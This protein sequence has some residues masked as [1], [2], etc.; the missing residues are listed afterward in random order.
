MTALTVDHAGALNTVALDLPDVFDPLLRPDRRAAR[1][2]DPLV[3]TF[4]GVQS[5]KHLIESMGIPHTEIAGLQVNGTWQSLDYHPQDGERLYV[6]PVGGG[7]QGAAPY[8]GD[9][10]RFVLDNHLGKLATYLRLLGFDCFYDQQLEDE[11]LARLSAEQ[12]R[13]LLSRDRG[14]LMRRQVTYGCWVASKTP[15]DQ[16]RLVLARYRLY[17]QVNPFSRCLRCNHPLEPVSKAEIQHRLLPLTK[18]YYEEFYLCR[19]CGQI[20]WPGSHY[21]HLEQVIAELLERRQ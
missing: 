12:T 20:Y 13:V 5:A 19:G 11:A 1:R 16:V 18:K 3:V 9:S 10:P 7:S 6:V 2:H 15:L 21:Q 8:P 17:D 4:K 14:L